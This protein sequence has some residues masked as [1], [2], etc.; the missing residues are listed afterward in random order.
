MKFPINRKEALS[1]ILIMLIGC[2]TII[3]SFN[4]SIGTL[5]RMG[6]GYFPL[7]LGIA[8]IIIGILM[9]VSS[10]V[11]PDNDSSI[12]KEK[13]QYRAWGCVIIS[14]VLFI[15]LGKF[16]GLVPATFAL[17]AV[18]ALANSSNTLKTAL[19]LSGAT[20]VIAVIIFHYGLQMQIPLFRWG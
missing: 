8:L 5:S 16:G 7:V 20:T 12:D 15:V 10:P 3:G 2:A 9:L 13:P 11:K 18:S 6:S 1:A 14:I 19:F 17:V 4:Y